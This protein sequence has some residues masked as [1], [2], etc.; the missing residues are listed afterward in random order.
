MNIKGY[1]Y[2]IEQQAI[3]AREMCD[4]FYGIPVSSEDITQNWVE[5]QLAE[6]NNPQFWY[7]IY[8]DSL[9]PVLGQPEEFD[10]I[11]PPTT[12]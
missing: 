9:I 7:F 12:I 8:D 2:D 1:K 4:A 3:D 6:F 10:V 11:V 5:Y